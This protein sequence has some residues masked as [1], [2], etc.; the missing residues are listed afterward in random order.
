DLRAS[1]SRCP[2]CG[3]GNRKENDS[4]ELDHAGQLIPGEVNGLP[5]TRRRRLI[6]LS[7]VGGAVLLWAI[8]VRF[9]P[10][11]R[12]QM[13]REVRHAQADPN[14]AQRRKLQRLF[15]DNFRL[16]LETIDSAH[17]ADP[18]H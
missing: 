13:D 6:I 17:V 15:D 12:E 4:S 11:D 8:G 10:P 3:Y 9:V 7:S 5:R 18:E 14:E 2:E 1:P 16:Q